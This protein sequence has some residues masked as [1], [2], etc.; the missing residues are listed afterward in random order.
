MALVMGPM[1][2]LYFLSILLARLAQRGKGE[3]E[4]S[5]VGSAAS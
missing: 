1:V 4:Q 5:Q 3:A 2:L